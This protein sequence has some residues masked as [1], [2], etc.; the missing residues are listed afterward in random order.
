MIPAKDLL[1]I[2]LLV[3]ELVAGKPF[4]DK[5]LHFDGLALLVFVHAVANQTFLVF[6]GEGE[7]ARFSAT[8][9][10]DEE[11][12]MLRHGQHFIG[13]NAIDETAESL[14]F[15]KLLK[16]LLKIFQ[17]K[18]ADELIEF[19]SGDHVV[20]WKVDQITQAFLHTIR[21]L[22]SPGLDYFNL[23]HVGEFVESCV[24]DVAKR[25]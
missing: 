25:F 10:D 14:S 13:L 7:E 23:D 16:V 17:A 5:L 22:L 1:E 19:V 11:K 18:E 2:Q 20:L 12:R 21:E 24:V 15:G 9:S 4:P 3:N 6:V 8:H